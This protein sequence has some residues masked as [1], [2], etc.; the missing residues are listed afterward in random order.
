MYDQSNACACGA[1][2]TAERTVYFVNTGKWK[3]V[4]FYSWYDAVAIY[5]NAWPGN[6]MTKVSG[7]VYSCSVPEDIPN[8]IFNDG[9]GTQTDD[10]VLPAA[11]EG[12]DTFDF[13]TKQWTTYSAEDFIEE[14]QPQE[15]TPPTEATEPVETT[16]PTQP[17]EQKDSKDTTSGAMTGLWIALGA[18][19]L[20]AIA[21]VVV[22]FIKKKQ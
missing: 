1:V 20:M 13:M 21:V 6:P 8:I 16:E 5:T 22:I 2:K 17:D 9:N 18:V 12:L 19:V 3:D 10:L 11:S 4:N 7:T 14:T 15:T